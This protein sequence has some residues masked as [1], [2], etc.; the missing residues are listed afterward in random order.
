MKEIQEAETLDPLSPS[1]SN[2]SVGLYLALGRTED[3]IKA[4]KRTLQIDPDFIYI[5]SAGADA[6]RENGEFQKAIE[7]YEKAQ[8]ATHFPSVGLAITYAKMGRQEEAAEYLE[9]TDKGI[10]AT[11]CRG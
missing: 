5:D 3:A 2:F 10:A 8:T 1:I 6:Y 9:S 4:G 11:I 7:L